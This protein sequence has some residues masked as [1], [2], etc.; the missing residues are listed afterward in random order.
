METLSEEKGEKV[1]LVDHK[2][3]ESKGKVREVRVS[4]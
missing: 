4:V 1:C 2:G 3:E